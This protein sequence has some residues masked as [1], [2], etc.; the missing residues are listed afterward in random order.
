MELLPLVAAEGT[1]GPGPIV[2][3]RSFKK[4]FNRKVRK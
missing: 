1:E 4:R 3:Y 2:P